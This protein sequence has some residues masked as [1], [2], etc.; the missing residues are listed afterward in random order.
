MSKNYAIVGCGGALKGPYSIA[1]I[2]HIIAVHGM[3]KAM[4][5]VSINAILLC[6]A[7][8]GE[9]QQAR[10]IFERMNKRHVWFGVPHV[11]RP[12]WWR[13]KGLFSLRPAYD[14][15]KKFLD[16]AKLQCPVEFG[17]VDRATKAYHQTRFDKDSSTPK[18]LRHMMASG[19]IGFFHEAWDIG[20][21]GERHLASD[22]GHVKVCP[23][24]PRGP[25]GEPVK[26]VHA[27]FHEDPRMVEQPRCEVNGLFEALL[28]LI[29]M[30][31]FGNLRSDW[32]RLQNW[33]R[34]DPTRKAWA[35]IPS[36]DLGGMWDAKA[37]TI[38]HRFKV[39]D[40][41]RHNP[42]AVHELVRAG[43]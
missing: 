28:W 3:P 4:A 25:D 23:D 14:T 41:D 8:C 21:D 9:L 37:E 10:R 27:L 15:A 24:V 38:A 29:E 12:A 1:I 40:K 35:Y 11:M 7:A 26:E 39:G 34:E 16:A 19:A 22:G 20:M 36:E 43:Q 31:L 33:C 32:E 17:W 30:M 5:G 42:I 6:A 18:M 2:E 13:R